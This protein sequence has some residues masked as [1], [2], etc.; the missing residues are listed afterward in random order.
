MPSKTSTRQRLTPR[1]S[2]RLDRSGGANQ[3]DAAG[4][5]INSIVAQYKKYG[6]IPNVPQLNP[7]F[8]DFSHPEDIHSMREAVYTAEERFNQLPAA[9][10]TLCDNDWVQFLD[11]FSDPAAQAEL[12]SAGLQITAPLPTTGTDHNSPLTTKTDVKPQNQS[13][14]PDDGQS[15]VKNT[16]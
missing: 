16:S 9:V 4:T 12:V 8:G 6:T 7:L 13:A 14:E 15:G 10:R 5:D 11:R 2:L 3:A 1:V